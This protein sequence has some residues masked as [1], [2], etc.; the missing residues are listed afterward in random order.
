MVPQ[1][2]WY[3]TAIV[4]KLNIVD[5][6]AGLRVAEKQTSGSAAVLLLYGVVGLFL[7]DLQIPD[8][9]HETQWVVEL[10]FLIVPL[11]FNF[12]AQ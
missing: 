4:L 3:W 6:C 10:E 5:P 7:P 8:Q 9:G 2:S 12:W 1:L 11:D